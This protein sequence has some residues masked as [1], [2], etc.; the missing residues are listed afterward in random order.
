MCTVSF[1]ARKRGYLLAMNRDEKLSRVKGL[2]PKTIFTEGRT[3]ILPC[4]KL[5]NGGTWIAPERCRRDLCIDPTG[6]P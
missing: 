4:S 1:I 5:R 6:I 3:V 2:P